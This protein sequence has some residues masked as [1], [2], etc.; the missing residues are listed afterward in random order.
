MDRLLSHRSLVALG[1]L[2]LTLAATGCRDRNLQVPPPAHYTDGPYAMPEAGGYPDSP[3]AAPGAS[4]MDPYGGSGAMPGYGPGGGDASGYDVPG[5]FDADANPTGGGFG[6]S[7]V[8]GGRPADPGMGAPS[9][10]G[11]P[12]IPGSAD[13]TSYG[14]SYASPSSTSA[15]A[16]D[17]YTTGADPYAGINAA[18]GMPGLPD[19]PGD[20]DAFSGTGRDLFPSTEP[21]GSTPAIPDSLPDMP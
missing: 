21:A 4:G 7:D 12:P 3:A 10:F 1:G 14:A 17:P 20:P 13:P 6:G 11:V 2:A 18:A 5:S 16:A 8:M 15:Y 19:S 9:D